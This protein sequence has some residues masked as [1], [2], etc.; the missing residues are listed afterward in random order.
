MAAKASCA[1]YVKRVA[2]AA[3]SRWTLDGGLG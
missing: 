3:E 2:T 1:F